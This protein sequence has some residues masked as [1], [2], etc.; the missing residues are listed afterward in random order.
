MRSENFAAG[1]NADAESVARRRRIEWCDNSAVVD[2]PL[3]ILVA[4]SVDVAIITDD[5]AGSIDAGNADINVR[6]G[7]R[8]NIYSG[9]ATEYGHR[10]NSLNSVQ[11]DAWRDRIY[12]YSP[13][14]PRQW[15]VGLKCGP[16]V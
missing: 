10:C 15:Q 12:D 14:A 11:S 9:K 3:E 8:R 2:K 4:R 5:F 13:N 6:P 16:E 1:G 7:R